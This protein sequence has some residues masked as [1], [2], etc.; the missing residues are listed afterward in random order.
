MGARGVPSGPMGAVGDVA[1]S[2]AQFSGGACRGARAAAQAQHSR[3]VWGIRA[4]YAPEHRW[5][6]QA[7]LPPRSCRP[8]QLRSGPHRAWCLSV[9]GWRSVRMRRAKPHHPVRARPSQRVCISRRCSSAH[10][11]SCLLLHPSARWERVGRRRVLA[12]PEQIVK[13][14]TRTR[15][16]AAVDHPWVLASIFGFPL[17]PSTLAPLPPVGLGDLG[18]SQESVPVSVPAPVRPVTEA[19]L[20][21]IRIETYIV[22]Y[23]TFCMAS[24]PSLGGACTRSHTDMLRFTHTPQLSSLHAMYTR[25]GHL[26]LHGPGCNKRACTSVVDLATRLYLF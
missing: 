4:A 2:L 13:A 5:G 14:T 21:T 16:C 24:L 10:G 11:G 1:N 20:D 7:V 26:F 9:G 25:V 23:L 19:M 6:S 18:H 8:R 22:F 12:M 3:F 17:A 15:Q